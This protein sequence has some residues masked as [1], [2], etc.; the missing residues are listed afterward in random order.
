ME[1]VEEWNQHETV[2]SNMEVDSDVFCLVDKTSSNAMGTGERNLQRQD[3]QK[4]KGKWKSFSSAV[5][6]STSISK[7]EKQWTD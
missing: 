7:S 3:V 1:T 5:L 6:L 2:L 4:R